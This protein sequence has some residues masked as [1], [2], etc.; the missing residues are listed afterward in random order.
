MNT[1]KIVGVTSNKQYGEEINIKDYSP[2]PKSEHMLF[3]ALYDEVID[4]VE[5][6]HFIGNEDAEIIIDVDESITI[7]NNYYALENLHD[8]IEDMLFN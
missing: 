5:E 8:N 3:E 1:I 2:P 4:R 7:A 6:A